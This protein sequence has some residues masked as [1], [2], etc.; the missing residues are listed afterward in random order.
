MDSET[1]KLA[2]SL[3]T[4]GI[5]AVVMFLIYRKDMQAA[6][7]DVKGERDTMTAI[8]I[9]NTAAITE[10]TTYL[11]EIEGNRDALDRARSRP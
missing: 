3:G 4:G 1:L 11:R 2:A 9:A 10:L 7:V 6:A 8:V 5:L